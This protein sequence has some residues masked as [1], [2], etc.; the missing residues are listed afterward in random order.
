[1]FTNEDHGRRFGVIATVVINAAGE[2]VRIFSG[3]CIFKPE[4]S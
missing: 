3:S 2:K 1:M 4:F